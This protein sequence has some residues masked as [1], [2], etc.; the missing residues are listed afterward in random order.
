MSIANSQNVSSTVCCNTCNFHQHLDQATLDKIQS[1]NNW[2]WA[3]N[4]IKKHPEH[5][6]AVLHLC[7]SEAFNSTLLEWLA[8]AALITPKVYDEGMSYLKQEPSTVQDDE[9]NVVD[10]RAHEDAIEAKVKTI[11]NWKHLFN[12]IKKYRD[13]YV[14][15]HSAVNTANP[16]AYTSEL[17][18]ALREEGIIASDAEL[19]QL[20]KYVKEPSRPSTPRSES[21]A[22]L[23]MLDTTSLIDK[24][25]SINNEWHMYNYIKKH[26]E[27]VHYCMVWSDWNAF[28]LNLVKRLLKD[29]LLDPYK[30]H[31]AYDFQDETNV[32]FVQHIKALYDEI[33]DE[34]KQDLLDEIFSL[35]E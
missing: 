29:G 15:Y 26:P 21:Q 9:M 22:E 25:K 28:T 34:D 23:K 31:P 16:S 11:T 5:T 3:F 24:I 7:D 30:M 6:D 33:A 2:K 4:Y 17:L 20:M 13:D 12:Y 8:S 10:L 35:V 27:Y 32:N 1:I 18:Y 19:Q 14:V